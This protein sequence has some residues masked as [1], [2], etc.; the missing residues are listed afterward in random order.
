MQTKSAL[1]AALKFIVCLAALFA[2]PAWAQQVAVVPTKSGT[3]C[4]GPGQAPC[5][6]K[7]ALFEGKPYTQCPYVRLGPDGTIVETSRTQR[8]G[9]RATA[10]DI[11]TGGCWI[12]PEG[13]SRD[14][15]NPA[16]GDRACSTKTDGGASGRILGGGLT[17][18]Q[19][20]DAQLAKASFRG[21]LC[22]TGT[23]YDGIRGG[24]CWTCPEGYV[25]SIMPV[26]HE[27]ACVIPSRENFDKATRVR[28]TVWPHECPAGSFH[29]IWEGGGCWT[30]PGGYRRTALHINDAR[31]CAQT[32]GQKDTTAKFEKNA[33][34][35][36]GEIRDDRIEGTQD[37]T[38]GGGCWT[39]PAGYVRSI[40][41]IQGSSGCARPS[42]LAFHKAQHAADFMCPQGQAFDLIKLLPADGIRPE[43]VSR[44]RP[45]EYNTPG[46]CWS[47]PPGYV[48]TAAHVK[49]DK[50]C[51]SVGIDWYTAP[52]PEPGLFGL[53][54]AADVLLETT[55]SNPDL[56]RR[57][58][59][60]LPPQA[61]QEERQLLA[62][63]PHKSAVALGLVA[64]RL[65]GALKSPDKATKAERELVAS[66][67][68]YVQARRTYVA[69]DALARYLA[70]KDWDANRRPKGDDRGVPYPVFTPDFHVLA[71]TGMVTNAAANFA[72][73]QALGKMGDKTGT[74]VGLLLGAA[75]NYFDDFKTTDRALA[76]LAR[77]GA[78]YAAGQALGAIMFGAA[79]SN[80]GPQIAVGAI[81]VVS[82]VIIDTIVQEAEARPKLQNA[83]KTAKLPPDLA[84]LTN[85]EH[86]MVELMTYWNYAVA[87]PAQPTANYL[88]SY[89][90]LAKDAMTPPAG[91]AASP[92]MKVTDGARDVSIGAGGHV[93]RL[94]VD[95]QP[96]G[97]GM[98]RLDGAS[99]TRMPGGAAQIA[100]DPQGH[101]WIVRDNR[102][103][104]RFDGRQ[105]IT[106]AGAAQSIA[107]GGNG[108]VWALGT[109][110]RPG[111]FSVAR[112][113]GSAWVIVPGGGGVKIAVDRGG[114][115]AVV[116]DK[117]S[118]LYFDGQKWTPMPGAAS[119]IAFGA[120]GQAWMLGTN[121]VGGGF[122]VYRWSGKDWAPV[123]I[124]RGLVNLAVAP[125]GSPWG[126]TAA[127]E[128]VRLTAA[129]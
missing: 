107:I 9:M 30:C 41:P 32:V 29:D 128:L 40:L 10:W 77:A 79:A 127:Q 44:Q 91:M 37:A 97:F 45:P 47:C 51:V 42:G 35:A 12:C 109:E 124:P 90:A 62:T 36:T 25:R 115:A 104:Q 102:Q 123:A 19:S 15:Y 98:Y 78:E 80:T 60:A 57:A 55:A 17:P 118:I 76:F 72:L 64:A 121:T 92:W 67:R 65:I 66:F 21:R 11:P 89:A 100:V 54:G 105:W 73:G 7:L 49:G 85:T 39:C 22:E 106:V 93:W 68:A 95:A 28:R 43:I 122:G 4:G 83:V 18:A 58:L 63:Q 48:R 14:I 117:G 56:L 81:L 103:V 20:Q 46:T 101:A 8:A 34:C 84:R 2:V 6:W 23:F 111:G 1:L 110:A 116:T 108:A 120:Q 33:L 114:N 53:A 13:Y 31:A 125:D 69:E 126:V 82:A 61:A 52:F 87:G 59:A 88:A 119:D 99:W 86:G 70:W 3:T 113:N 27:R 74:V 24:T 50:A 129:R 16:D 112:W 71:V 26:T 96:G 94:G 38:A 5:G 75:G